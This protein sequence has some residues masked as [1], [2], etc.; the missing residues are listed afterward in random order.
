[1]ISPSNT[2]AGLT[3]EGIPPPW[4]YRGEP[5]VYYPTG[6]PQLRPGAAH[7]TTCTAPRMPC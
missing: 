3:R 2:Y 4:G 7:Q 1:M 5:D 6:E